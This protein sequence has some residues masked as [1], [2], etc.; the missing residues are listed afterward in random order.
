M[1]K[2]KISN[3]IILTA[4]LGHHIIRKD[5]PEFPPATEVWLGV[6]EATDNYMEVEVTTNE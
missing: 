6:G 1:Q 5:D 2:K 3:T 4:A